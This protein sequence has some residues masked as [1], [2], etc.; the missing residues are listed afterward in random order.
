MASQRSLTPQKTPPVPSPPG[1]RKLKR[2][3]RVVVPPATLL[4]PTGTVW[5]S[6]MTALAIGRRADCDIVLDDPLVSR[7]H[8]FIVAGIDRVE[9]EDVPSRNGTYLN[10]ERLTGTEVLRSGDRIVI[11]TT[12]ISGFSE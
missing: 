7:L 8:A 5:L 11:G 3:G 4:L 6:P 9:L 1:S 2:D 12:E 10:G